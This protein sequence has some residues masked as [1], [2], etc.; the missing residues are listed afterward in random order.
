MIGVDVVAGPCRPVPRPD[1]CSLSEEIHRRLHLRPVLQLE[2]DV[3]AIWVRLPC[4]KLMVW[5]V[6]T[7]AQ[8]HEQSWIQSETRKP[9]T[10]Q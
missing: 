8:E 6:G 4:T 9:I 7:A 5:V 1:R 3:M 10:L 2:G